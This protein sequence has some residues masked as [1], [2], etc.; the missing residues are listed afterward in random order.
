[1]LDGVSYAYPAWSGR[2]RA[3]LRHVDL[4]VAP[5][6]TLVAGD[7]GAGKSTLLR[8][9]NGL[10]PHFHGGVVSGR[11][12]VCGRDVLTTPTRQLARHVG[13]VFQEPEV[14]FVRGTVE[15]EVAFGPEN[16]GLEGRVIRARVGEALECTGIAAL[17][18]RRLRTLSGGERQRVA[19]AAALAMASEVVVMDEP[20]S[21]L[22]ETGAAALA[23]TLSE[24]AGRGRTVL[25]AEHR[26]EHAGLAARAVGVV[27][28]AVQE[29]SLAALPEPG[30]AACAE[31]GTG[32]PG[33][34]RGREA[35]RLRRAVIGAGATPL[36]EDVDLAGHEGEVVVVTGANGVGK[37]TLLRTLAGLTV[38]L[39]G[40]VERRPGRVAYLPQE[41]GVLLHRRSVRDE[42]IQT[43]RWTQ[44]PG[45]GDDVLELLGLAELA[46]RD[47]RDLSV[48]QRQRAALAAVLVGRP[49]I[50]LL[51]E[52][53]RGMDQAA[54]R[55]LA[56]ALRHLTA[57][58]A[59]V[60]LATH[61]GHLARELGGRV[62]RIED[63]RL[64]HEVLGMPA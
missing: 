63:R 21:Q 60:V 31:S 51:D 47:P 10:V 28:G 29:T 46:G 13:F 4:V 30:G 45:T 34:N 6:L 36:V 7:S 27:D 23:S 54:R 1:V 8:L 16:H 18:T 64:Q 50:A 5:G 59:S 55:S 42:I 20:L 44:T 41:P 32:A 57:D 33:G 58:G 14:G 24:L 39:S 22:D 15:R 3:A 49:S 26:L 11:A 52:P 62:V 40:A 43:L 17:A 9:L 12:T 61:D 56:A 38:P 53:T 25:V 37:T 48:G 2:P 35:W 19:L